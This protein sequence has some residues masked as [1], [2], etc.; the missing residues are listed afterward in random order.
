MA[1][2]KPRRRVA[3]AVSVLAVL[4]GGGVIVGS[5][6]SAG[7]YYR[8]VGETVGAGD[9]FVGE[10]FRLAG[11]VAEGTLVA[12][13]GTAPDYTFGLTDGTGRRLTVHYARAVPDAFKEG[14]EVVAEGTLERPDRF[15]ARLVI[16]KCPSKYEGNLYPDDVDGEATGQAPARP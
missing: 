14:V 1:D 3:A 15:E 9:A 7:Q 12:A 8:T 16:A 6:F 5:S 13:P 2:E 10:S 4:A 11:K